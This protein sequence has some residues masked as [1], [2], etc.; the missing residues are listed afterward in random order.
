M[1]NRS[2]VAIRR[3][4][5]DFVTNKSAAGFQQHK[6]AEVSAALQVP[7]W[8]ESFVDKHLRRVGT[9]YEQTPNGA[10]CFCYHE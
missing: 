4:Q 5:P 2:H 9:R 8:K 6:V 7:D 3:K 1:E 10:F